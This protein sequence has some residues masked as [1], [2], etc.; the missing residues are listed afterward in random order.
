MSLHEPENSYD[1]SPAGLMGRG[2]S[3]RDILITAHRDRV[4]ILVVLMIGLVLSAVAAYMAPKS[5]TAEAALLLRLGREYLYQPEVGDSNAGQ[6]MTADLEQTQQAEAKILTS[7]DVVNGVVDRMGA[8][9]IYPALASVPDSAKRRSLAAQSVGRSV[10][11]ELLKGSNLLQV[12]FKHPNAEI[13]S[14]VLQQ[15]IDAYMQKRLSVFSSASYGTA[16]AD[17]ATRTAEL[18]AAEAKVTDFKREHGIQSFNEEQTLLLAQR[19]ALEQ[20]QT[21]IAL[22][23]SQA[24][25]R[26]SALRTRLADIPTEVTLQTETQR[27][28]AAESARKLLLDLKLKERD[29]SSKFYESEAAVQDVRADSRRTNEYLHEL[30][31]NPPRSVRVGRSPVRDSAESELVHA[32]ADLGQ[33]QAGRS[34]LTDQ[35]AAIDKRLA[36]LSDSEGELRRLERESRLSETNYEVA[37]KRLRNETALADLDRKRKSNVSIVQRP[38]VP[39]EAKSARG[40]ILIIG[41]LLSLCAALATAFLSALWRDTFLTPDQ[42][43]RDLGLPMLATITRAAP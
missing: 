23:L 5:Y 7:L 22:A 27:G 41:V 26:T 8:T 19:N 3:F 2:T 39:L 20:R 32:T 42:V 13:A 16:Q 1:A 40:V 35:R 43:Q 4:R 9:T 18:N 30:E 36:E 37:A 12:S 21:D 28:E 38:T 15:L 10:D 33:A 24:N 17:F 14:S 25:G 31:A 29:A 11:A 6:P 34:T